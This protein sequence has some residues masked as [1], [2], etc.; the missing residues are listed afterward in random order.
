MRGTKFKV[1]LVRCVGRNR[2]VESEASTHMYS[3]HY[4]LSR[5]VFEEYH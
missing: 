4:N 3:V 1:K 2:K 5:L